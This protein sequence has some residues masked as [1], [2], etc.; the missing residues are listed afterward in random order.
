MSVTLNLQ[1]IGTGTKDFCPGLTYLKC[2][3]CE[4]VRKKSVLTVLELPW[5]LRVCC[6]LSMKYWLTYWK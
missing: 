6:Q 1:F 3:F 5:V 4:L 2:E